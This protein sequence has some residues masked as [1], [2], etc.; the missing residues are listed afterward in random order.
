MTHSLRAFDLLVAVAF[1][2]LSVTGCDGSGPA[3]PTSPQSDGVLTLTAASVSVDGQVLQPGETFHHPDGP[4]QATLFQATLMGPYGPATGHV[5]EVRF[6]RPDGM[7]NRNGAFRLYDDG[8]NGDPVAGDGIYCYRDPDGLYGFHHGRAS[9][10]RYHYDFCGL[11][12]NG[13]ETNH[14]V[15]DID[16]AP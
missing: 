2:A 6:R 4:A 16:V 7:M 8:T 13:A 11:Y 1:A 10:G 12:A 9:Q 15:V 5:V 3:S 14:W